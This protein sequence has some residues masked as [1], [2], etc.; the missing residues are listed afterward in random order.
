MR[1]GGFRRRELKLRLTFAPGANK[2]FDPVRVAGELAAG[3]PTVAVN[4]K[5]AA[6]FGFM[7]YCLLG[8]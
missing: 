7:G 3:V 8:V 6:K 5:A 1:T 2:A 4:T